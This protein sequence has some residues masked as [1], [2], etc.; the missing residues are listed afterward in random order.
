MALIRT[1]RMIPFAGQLLSL[2]WKLFWDGRVSPF[3]KILP[4]AAA[5]YVLSP[6]DLLRD[7]RLGLG[8]IDDVVVTGVLL[9]L[10]VLWAP[11][12]LVHEHLSGRGSSGPDDSKT[13]EGNFRYTDS[14]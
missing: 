7:F 6:I 14:E 2:T 4:I 5:I 9:L 1:L 13:V 8:Q 11:K 12:R 10:F 3:L